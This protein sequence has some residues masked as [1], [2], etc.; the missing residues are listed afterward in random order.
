[1]TMTQLLE[2]LTK[3]A[4]VEATEALRQLVAALNG[5]AAI[6]MIKEEVWSI[7]SPILEAYM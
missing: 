7:M 4:K 3:H 1:M 6:Y 2:K 5:K